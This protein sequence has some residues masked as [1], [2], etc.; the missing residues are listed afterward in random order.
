M[1]ARPRKA[2][3]TRPAAKA[4]PAKAT[5]GKSDDEKSG[6]LNGAI[7]EATDDSN[8]ITV[9]FRKAKFEIDRDVLG[10]ARFLM[11]MARGRDHEILFEV[12]GDQDSGRFINLCK[13]GEQLPPV[14]AEFFKA[15]RAAAGLGNS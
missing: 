14:A 1:P 9:E 10:S 5:A 3:T 7:A 8:V 2:A 12:L 6:A 13:R 15:V 4:T 11:A